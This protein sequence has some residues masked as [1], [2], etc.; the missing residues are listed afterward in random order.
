[1]ETL[2]PKTEIPEVIIHTGNWGTGAYGGDKVLMA[3]LQLL[4]AHLA[5]IDKLVFHTF[6]K[7]GSSAFKAAEVLLEKLLTTHTNENIVNTEQLIKGIH[8]LGFK[9]GFS[10]GN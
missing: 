1:M 5:G 4:A 6:D 7:T 8:A 9:W 2:D 10:D 3:M